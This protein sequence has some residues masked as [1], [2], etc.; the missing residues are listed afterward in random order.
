MQICDGRSGQSAYLLFSVA[1]VR[2]RCHV[3]S[4]TLPYG[5]I[6]GFLDRSCCKSSSDNNVLKY[7]KMINQQRSALKRHTRIKYNVPRALFCQLLAFTH[8]LKE[9]PDVIISEGL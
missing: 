3:V 1:L 9:H 2:K 6:L 5:R 7:H 4:V 8:L